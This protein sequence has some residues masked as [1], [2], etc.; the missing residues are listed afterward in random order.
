MARTYRRKQAKFEYGWVL[1]RAA[2]IQLGYWQ[3][4]GFL[5]PIDR[6]SKQG[7]AAL[8]V[9]HSDATI[10]LRSGP[11]RRFRKFFEHSMRQDNKRE[12]EKWMRNDQHE[13]LCSGRH[14][15][16]ATWEWW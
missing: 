11:P 2:R 9:F 16:S 15:H 10:T 1:N 6:R 12:V 3:T 13:P 5:A 7:R 8:A 4:Q 14:R